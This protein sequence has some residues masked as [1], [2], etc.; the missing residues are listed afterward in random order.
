MKESEDHFA[1]ESYVMKKGIKIVHT[2]KF[3]DMI[4]EGNFNLAPVKIEFDGRVFVY[5][6]E[7]FGGKETFYCWIQLLGSQYEAKNY[8]YTLEFQGND[9]NVRTIHTGK[10]ISVDVTASSIKEGCLNFGI[11]FNMLKK[12]FVGDDRA[13]VVSIGIRNMK[14]EAKDDNEESGISDDE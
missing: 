4:Y 7:H 1:N 13:Y 3:N 10:V 5:M 8:Y 12:Q 2:H 9:P 14:E 6:G 11:N